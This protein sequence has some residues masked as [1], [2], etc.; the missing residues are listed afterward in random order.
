MAH[1]CHSNN[2]DLYQ[3]W[4]NVNTLPTRAPLV[5]LVHLLL[6]ASEGPK[7]DV[8]SFLLPSSIPEPDVHDRKSFLFCDVSWIVRNVL[9]FESQLQGKPPSQVP[10]TPHAHMRL[11]V[12]APPQ[13]STF[14]PLMSLQKPYVPPSRDTVI[15]TAPRHRYSMDCEQAVAAWV[16]ARSSL[17]VA[18]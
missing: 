10:S 16:M 11:L 13:L 15:S 8:A 9:E 2:H 5:E 1:P 18:L 3:F 12:G 4:G 6:L 14:C 17:I 7:S